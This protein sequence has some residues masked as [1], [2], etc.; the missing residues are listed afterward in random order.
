MYSSSGTSFVRPEILEEL[1][2]LVT[3]EPEENAEDKVK[4][5]SVIC[6]Y[7]TCH[8]CDC[9]HVYTCTCTCTMFI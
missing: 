2:K 9:I 5:K 7:H 1:V 4:F 6:R 8:M 3:L